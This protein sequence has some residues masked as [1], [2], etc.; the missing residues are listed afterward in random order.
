MT[1]PGVSGAFRKKLQLQMY[2]SILWNAPR[3]TRTNVQEHSMECTAFYK[4]K[5]DLN[6]GHIDNT[7]L[8]LVAPP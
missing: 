5:C 3:S 4:N 6:Y 7:F 8:A 2:K 1:F